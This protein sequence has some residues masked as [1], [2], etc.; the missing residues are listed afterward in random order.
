MTRRANE[1]S[2]ARKAG[3][4]RYFTGKPCAKGHIAERFVSS[5]G[6]VECHKSD[7]HSSG[8]WQKYRLRNLEKAKQSERAQHKRSKEKRNAYSRAYNKRNRKR[9]NEY[10]R[11]WLKNAPLSSRIGHILRSR[12]HAAIKNKQKAG[13]AIRDL[14]CSIDE[15][16][17]LINAKFRSGMSWNNWGEV[18]ELD[19]IMPVALF[20]LSKRD[21]FLKACH[22]T[23]LQPLLVEEHNFKTADD[24]RRIR[25][26]EDPNG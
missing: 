18:W 11:Q 23:N 10:Q 5:K 13:S 22:F 1:R 20:D 6:C 7:S 21:Q 16:I 25:Q 26:K 17:T 2:V 3:L 19:H 8:Y 12:L 4:K 9:L 14:G 24:I 15:F